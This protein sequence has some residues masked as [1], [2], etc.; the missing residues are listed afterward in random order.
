MARVF[1]IVIANCNAMVIS[2][3]LS[4]LVNIIINI[5]SGINLY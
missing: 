1:M 2:F 5:M 4:M 3:E